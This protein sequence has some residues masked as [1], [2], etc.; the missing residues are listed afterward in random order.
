MSTVKRQH[1][2]PRFLLNNFTDQD[3]KIYVFTRQKDSPFRTDPSNVACQKYYNAIKIDRE[4]I[5][6]QTIEKELSQI[7]GAGSDVINAILSGSPP[8]QQ[9]REDLSLFITSQDFRSPRRRQEYADMLLGIEHHKFTDN[10]TASVENYIRDVIEASG[11]KKEFDFSNISTESELRIDD[12]GTITVDFEATIHALSTAK[13]FSPIVSEMDWHLFRAPRGNNFI[14]CD[15]P[16]Q[17]YESPATLEKFS[18]PAYWRKGSYIS[19][20]LASDACLVAS[21]RPATEGFKWPPR[22]TVTEAK[23]SDVRFLNQLQ[24]FGC[25]KQIY[26]NFEYNWLGK[27][28]ATLPARG[29]QLSFMPVDE[30]GKSLSVKMDR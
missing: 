10:T 26:A 27:K 4:N 2:V 1:Y 16:V 28:C 7:E 12:D 13:H 3:G 9:Q 14:I 29:P 11:S 21:H 22:F 19:I 30:N 17:I 25:L 15:S 5:D 6:T 23:G 18:A 24:L 20:P 8:T